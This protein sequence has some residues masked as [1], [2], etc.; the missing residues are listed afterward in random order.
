MPVHFSRERLDKLADQVVEAIRKTPGA[1]VLDE[2]AVRACF[3]AVV[4]ADLLEEARIEKE[5]AELLR[6][7]GQ[8]IYEQNADFHKMLQEGKRILAKKQ[9]FT[10]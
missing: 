2:N 6:A 4:G 8:Q 3:R 7:H 10:L 1:E 5:A 9:G